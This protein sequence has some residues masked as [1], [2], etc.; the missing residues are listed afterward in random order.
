MSICIRPATSADALVA[1]KVLRQSIQE[2]CYEDH[3]GN[4]TALEAWLKNKTPE[5]VSQWIQN[6]E[7]FS[8]V[9]LVEEEIVGFAMS[10]RSGYVLLCYLIPEVQ[11]KGVGKAMLKAIEAQARRDSISVLHLESTQTARPFYLR[12]QFV[13]NGPPIVAFGISSYPMVKRLS[14]SE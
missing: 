14:Q 11:H 13:Q 7:L 3:Q 12:N 9:A 4:A 10:N 5:N 8:V 1:S 6:P 2:I